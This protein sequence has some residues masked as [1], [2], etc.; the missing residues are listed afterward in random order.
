MNKFGLL[1]I[2]MNQ[3][4]FEP[5]ARGGILYHAKEYLVPCINVLASAFRKR[6][7][8]VV[9]VTQRWSDDFSDAPLL[10]RKSGD[11]T[12]AAS[13]DGWKLLPELDVQPDDYLIIK[14]NYSAFFGT[15][16]HGR[17]R[18]AGVTSLVIAGVNTYACVRVTTLD[19]YQHDYDPIIWP[20]EGIAASFPQFEQD[21]LQYMIGDTPGRSLV[22]GLL[23]NE[24]II[25]RL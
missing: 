16:L 13:S 6:D 22:E 10:Q 15:D 7:L 23:S 4:S 2:D 20:R 18:L 9:W 17:L 21:T 12:F 25:A 3:G 1:V 11:R 24:E 8:P 14:R 19:A 5:N